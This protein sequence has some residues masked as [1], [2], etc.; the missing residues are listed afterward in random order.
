MFSKPQK[1]I[2][3]GSIFLFVLSYLC[4]VSVFF[5]CLFCGF[6]CN[7]SMCVDAGFLFVGLF[8]TELFLCFV[9]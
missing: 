4:V 8:A 6:L 3:V 5:I 7:L 1:K 9:T 2:D